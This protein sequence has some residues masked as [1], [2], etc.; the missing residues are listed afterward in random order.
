[1][2]RKSKWWALGMAG[3]LAASLMMAGAVSGAAEVNKTDKRTEEAFERLLEAGIIQGDSKGNLNLDGNITRAQLTTILVKAIGL[4]DGVKKPVSS[5]FSDVDANAW[6]AGYVA[7]AIKH[8]EAAGLRLGTT[9]STFSPDKKLSTIETLVFV[10]KFL[11]I[12]V[13]KGKG[14]HWATD[15]FNAAIKT[16]L[17]TSDQAKEFSTA[18][19]ANRKFVFLLTDNTFKNYELENGKTIYETYHDDTITG[20]VYSDDG[21]GTAP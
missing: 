19:T 6:Y 18:K 5:G 15:A 10:E 20:E 14:T 7:A 9:K 16:G 11:G 12:E 13:E 8:V 4:D 17:V 3:L 2:I 21:A 1:M